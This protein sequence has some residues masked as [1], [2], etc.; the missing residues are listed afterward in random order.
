MCS[1]SFKSNAYHCANVLLA[2][3]YMASM[4]AALYMASMLGRQLQHAWMQ[5]GLQPLLVE[6]WQGHGLQL[7]GRKQAFEPP[8]ELAGGQALL[9]WLGQGRAG[10]FEQHQA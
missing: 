1:I 2:A 7:P 10:Y 9:P 4:L 6:Q 8:A 3:L 5:H